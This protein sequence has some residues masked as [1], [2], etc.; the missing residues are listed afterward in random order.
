MTLVTGSFKNGFYNFLEENI[1]SDV[2]L[3]FNGSMYYS[4]QL[5]LVSSSEVFDQIITKATKEPQ[6][7]NFC[8]CFFFFFFFF[9]FCFLSSFLLFRTRSFGFFFCFLPLLF[10]CPSQILIYFRYQIND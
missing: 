4:H 1:F 3:H 7:R 9:L 6:G 8:F 5:L 2:I 10:L